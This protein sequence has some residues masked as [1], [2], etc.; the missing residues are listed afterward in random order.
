MEIYSKGRDNG[1][2]VS[3]IGQVEQFCLSAIFKIVYYFQR[4][5]YVCG[6]SVGVTRPFCVAER[7]LLGERRVP[8]G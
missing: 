8:S 3:G 4:A 6:F 5:R 2:F 1:N 7:L